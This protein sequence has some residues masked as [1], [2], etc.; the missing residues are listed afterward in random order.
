MLNS[1]GN[2]FELVGDIKPLRPIGKTNWSKCGDLWL[3]VADERDVF[4][5]SSID[6]N[7]PIHD[8]THLRGMPKPSLGRGQKWFDGTKD[9]FFSLDVPI[10][11]T[12]IEGFF[13]DSESIIGDY[14]VTIYL[15]IE[16]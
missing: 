1:E 8:T 12:I 9:E 13:E 5:A 4:Y 10:E 16:L 7:L 15:E 3:R 2:S 11:N 14:H 6:M